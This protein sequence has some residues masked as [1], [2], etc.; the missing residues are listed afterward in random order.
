MRALLVCALA[1][2]HVA[3]SP[4]HC[5]DNTVFL[6]YTLV[7]GAEA[8]NLIDVTVAIGTDAARTSTVAHKTSR[9]SGSIELSFT[10]YPSGK[11]LVVGLTARADDVVL[12]S[13]SQTTTTMPGCTT[14]SLG[15]DGS[16]SSTADLSGVDLGGSAPDLMKLAGQGES[17]SGSGGCPAGL[18]CVDGVCCDSACTGQ[19][20]ACNLSGSVGT[21]ATVTSGLPRGTRT[22]CGGS[23]ACTGTCTGASPIQCTY[24][25]S[26]TVCGAACDGTCD[27]AGTCSSSGGGSCP[28]GFGCMASGCR[29]TCSVTADCQPNFICNAPNCVR[30]PESDCLDGLDNNGD[31]KADCEDPTCTEVTCVSAVGA[32]NEIGIFQDTACPASDFTVASVQHQTLTS[33]CGGCTCSV[34]MSCR[35]PFETF[36]DSACGT[37]VSQISTLTGTTD[38]GPGPCVNNAAATTP[39]SVK[40]Y[41]SFPSSDSGTCVSGG[42]ANDQSSWGASKSFC[43]AARQSNTCGGASQVC[44]KKPPAATPMCVR[45][46]AGAASC[47]AGYPNAQGTWYSGYSPAQCSCGTCTKTSDGTCPQAETTNGLRFFT[48]SGC[49]MEYG[50][51]QNSEPVS[52]ACLGK[53]AT[54]DWS[55]IASIQFA[56]PIIPDAPGTCT[57]P[58]NTDVA[59][60]PT[61]PS[62]ICCQ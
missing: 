58:T 56:G 18:F 15:L 38:P 31:G 7:N 59:A 21:C 14:L 20:Q 9:A 13:T 11:S 43:G 34:R 4:V 53:S 3:C 47:P 60:T 55:T 29:T 42:S 35:F 50:Y 26:S 32:G 10:S 30:I 51:L 37:I 5:K 44:V 61:G 8:A 57:R 46:P 28:N 23:G 25:D 39:L 40:A 12:A 19:C 41:A 24:P 52:P 45:V 62:T 1:L 33:Q 22:G 48:M 27:G 2:T 49:A 54:R 16:D 6:S 17:C 36:S